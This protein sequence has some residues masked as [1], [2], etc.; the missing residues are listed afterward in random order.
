MGDVAGRYRK[1]FSAG[2]DLQSTQVVDGAGNADEFT[3]AGQGGPDPATHCEAVVPVIGNQRRIR[4]ACGAPGIDTVSQL[5]KY[6]A[7][8]HSAIG[9]R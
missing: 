7:R 3:A 1:D 8:Q 6:A 2:V 9:C 4:A 5:A